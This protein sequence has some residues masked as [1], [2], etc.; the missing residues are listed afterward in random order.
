[1][2]RLWLV[3]IAVLALCVIAPDAVLAFGGGGR[4]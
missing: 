2:S 4:R 1:M 3:A